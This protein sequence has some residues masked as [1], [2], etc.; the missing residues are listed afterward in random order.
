MNCD[1]LRPAGERL[2][3]YIDDELPAR[4]A[5]AVADHLAQ[6][7]DCA[8]EYEALL[9][10]GQRMRELLPPL[11]APDTLRARVR[12][13]LRATPPFLRDDPAG[14]RAALIPLARAT[15]MARWRRAAA[16]MALIAVGGVGTLAGVRLLAPRPT[17]TDELV[18]GHV[19]SLLAA[20]LTDVASTDQHTVKPWYT[21]KLDFSPSVPR[22]DSAGFTLIGGRLDYVGR[23][24]VAAL[25]YRRRQHVIN[26]FVQPAPPDAAPMADNVRGFHLVRWAKGGLEYIAVSDLNAAELAQF[27]SL[28]AAAE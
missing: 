16:A 21:G 22:L 18:A 7:A 6:C 14:S 2:G 12:H 8:A 11:T 5:Q 20:H 23:R 24:A 13:D 25:V 27:A 17:T 28:F 9:S 10:L 19:R 26:V 15:G 4:D 3:A 1:E